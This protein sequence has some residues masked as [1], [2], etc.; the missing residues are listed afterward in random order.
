MLEPLLNLLEF[1]HRIILLL[2][3]KLSVF[4]LVIIIGFLYLVK[5]SLDFIINGQERCKKK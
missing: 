2:F 1:L 5:Y 4:V 3:V